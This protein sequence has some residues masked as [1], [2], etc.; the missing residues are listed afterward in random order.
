M[1]AAIGVRARILQNLAQLM[2]VIDIASEKLRLALARVSQVG[3]DS[4]SGAPDIEL[5]RVVV[6]V[7]LTQNNKLALAPLV[8]VFPPSVV[9]P[10]AGDFVRQ[11]AHADG[12]ARSI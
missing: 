9:L 2:D 4:A 1:I 12:N 6:M 11:K 7:T 3:A 5:H 10:L 8:V